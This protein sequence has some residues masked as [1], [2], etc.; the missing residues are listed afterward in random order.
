VRLAV[1]VRYR[2][3]GAPE[4][5]AWHQGTTENISRTGV[6]IR[7][8]QLAPLGAEVDVILTLPPGILADLAG[9]I[10]CAGAVARQVSDAA[11]PLGIAVMFRKCRP[12][13]AGRA[14]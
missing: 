5:A 7:A 2:V 4:D 9:E 6:L 14:R 3:I 11:G 13:V 12:T 8:P 10:I 1:P